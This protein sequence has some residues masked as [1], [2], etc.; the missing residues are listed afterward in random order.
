MK[1]REQAGREA[2]EKVKNVY[3]IE[4]AAKLAGDPD[5]EFNTK[6]ALKVVFHNIA[7]KYDVTQQ[8]VREAMQEVEAADKEDDARQVRLKYS[9]TARMHDKWIHLPGWQQVVLLWALMWV[10]VIGI[11][12]MIGL[13]LMA[14]RFVVNAPEDHWVHWIARIG[15]AGIAYGEYKKFRDGPKK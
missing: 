5:A 8:M 15:V 13:M 1:Q 14:Y 7:K 9:W 6:L 12:G 2:L 10:P 3:E 4:Q 11:L